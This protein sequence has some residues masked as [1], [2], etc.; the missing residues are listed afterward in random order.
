MSERWSWIL[1]VSGLVLAGAAGLLVFSIA[2]PAPAPAAPE[3]RTKVV[4]A[5]TDIRE[6]TV[7]TA[8]ML[9]TREYRVANAPAGVITDPAAAVGRTTVDGIP[10]GVPVTEK[11]LTGAGAPPGATSP[12]TL[13]AGTVLM[14]FPA[15]DPLS[16]AKGVQPGDRVDIHASL[17]A[18][19]ANALITQSIVQDLEVVAVTGER[20]T[21]LTFVVDRQTSLVL[22]YL[23]DAQAQID[24]VVRSRADTDRIR[25]DAVDLRYLVETYGVQRAR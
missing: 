23:K 2:R 25:S 15:T 8:E 19:E 11:D 4:V 21:L 12:L 1:L 14:V 7:L 16:Q 17:P 13:R 24:L 18:G 9:T 20:P 6:L 5:A 3:P 10:A 22:K